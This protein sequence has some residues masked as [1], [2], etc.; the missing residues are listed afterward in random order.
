MYQNKPEDRVI[1]PAHLMLI[2]L[3]SG[4]M[5]NFLN[6]K[7]IGVNTLQ[8]STA[9]SKIRNSTKVYNSHLVHTPSAFTNKYYSLNSTFSNENDYLTTSSFGL[10]KQHNLSSASSYGNSFSSTVLDSQ[11]FDKFLTTNLN[12]N[13]GLTSESSLLAPSPLS[14]SRDNQ[15]VSTPNTARLSSLLS[16]NSAPSSSL[17]KLV[18]YPSLLSNINDNSDKAGLSYPVTKLTSPNVVSGDFQNSN[19][20]S[21]QAQST[22]SSST[23]SNYNSLTRGNLST[24]TKVFNLSGPNSKVLLGDQSIRAHG[25]L[26]PSKSNYNLSTGLNTLTSNAQFGARFGQQGNSF[27]NALASESNYADYSL[28]NNLASSRAFLSESHPAVLSSLPSGSNSLDYDATTAKTGSTSYTLS[29][30]LEESSKTLK[31]SVGDVFVGSREKTPR[32]VN[33]AY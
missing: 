11:S 29:G 10:R 22:D 9:F 2:P 33:T 25:Q 28:T 27:Q 26:S 20:T 31:S 17:T 12:V 18:A 21:Q 7:N 30:E 6:F 19:V 16:L 15:V 14:L 13:T 32:A 8:E 4:S 3:D 5:T 23:T 1:T 24:S